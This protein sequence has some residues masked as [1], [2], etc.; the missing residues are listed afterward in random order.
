MAWALGEEAEK[1]FLH[2]K[3]K[4]VVSLYYFFFLST[5]VAKSDIT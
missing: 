2:A 1:Y 5:F 3:K 4:F